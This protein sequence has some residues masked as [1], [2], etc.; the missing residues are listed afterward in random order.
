MGFDNIRVGA[1]LTP[2]LTTLFHPLEKA[3]AQSMQLLLGLMKDDPEGT[4]H[5]IML[6]P[7]LVERECIRTSAYSN[8]SAS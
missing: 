5:Q 6:K 4:V 1:Y 7:E 8:A 2:T 3:A